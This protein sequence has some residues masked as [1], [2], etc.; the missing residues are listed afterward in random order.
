MPDLTEAK[1]QQYSP[2]VSWGL[3][4]SQMW[5]GNCGSSCRLTPRNGI[6]YMSYWN[7]FAFYQ[8]GFRIQAEVEHCEWSNFSSCT[9]WG[10]PLTTL[11][12][13]WMY[14]ECACQDERNGSLRNVWGGNTDEAIILALATPEQPTSSSALDEVLPS[15]VTEV[16]NFR[17]R[18]Q[19]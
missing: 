2:S 15:C 9:F 14:K 18:H 16:L 7:H 17:K 11:R 12:E 13:F 10:P 4:F 6:I 1:V 19:L 3:M 5:K 8:E